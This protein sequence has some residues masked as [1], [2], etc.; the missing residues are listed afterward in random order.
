MEKTGNRKIKILYV[1]RMLR[2]TGQG[3][4]LSM[5]AILDGLE[6]MGV[7][8]E[9]KSVYAD[10]EILR[11]MGMDIRYKRGTGYFLESP[12][13]KE[14]G[15][16]GAAQI[17][18]PEHR[19]EK[20]EEAAT[21]ETIEETIEETAEAPELTVTPAAAHTAK[22]S[23]PVKLLCR[24]SA[25]GELERVFGKNCVYKEKGTD[26]FTVSVQVEE[27]E[28]FYGWLAFMGRNVHILKP[29]KAALAYR[30]YLKSIVKEYKDAAK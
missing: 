12:D 23:K 21:E 9:R 10:M 22:D 27:D 25:R 14:S 17:S 6:A 4:A 18:A 13:Y 1:E 8:A 28:R 2:E 16:S 3:K 24:N 15:E 11:S 19:L 5:Q 20:T 29:K 7:S 30:D 26:S